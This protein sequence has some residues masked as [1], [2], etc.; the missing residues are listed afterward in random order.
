MASTKSLEERMAE[1]KA[2]QEKLKQEMR[3][4]K[5][6]QSQEERK[7]R[8]KRLIEVGAVVEKALGMEFETEQQ[9]EQLL[10]VLSEIKQNRQTGE[11]Y[12]WGTAIANAVKRRLGD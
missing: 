12:S 1:N 11:Q 5:N 10:A 8:T 4:L 3:K 6:K 2:K 9:R 7:K